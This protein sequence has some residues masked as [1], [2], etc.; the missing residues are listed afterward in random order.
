MSSERREYFRV[1]DKVALDYR[2]IN[3]S[4]LDM[5]RKKIMNNTAGRFTTASDFDT[6][7][8]QLGHAIQTVKAESPEVAH[9]LNA[10]DKKLNTLAQIMVSDEIKLD[11]YVAREAN[12]S[13][14]GIAFRAAHQIELGGLLETRIVLLPSM[15]GILTVSR[16]IVC[17]HVNDEDKK[18][19]W[20]IAVSHEVLREADRELMVRHVMSKETE[21]LR[22]RRHLMT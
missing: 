11:D 2:I 13:A 21:R 1:N 10:I 20:R 17:D 14:G 3:G 4:D 8:H 19:P 7:S 16:V 15:I 5:L 9:C 22:K 6:I 18:L 12:I